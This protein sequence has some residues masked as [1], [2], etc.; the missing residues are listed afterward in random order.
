MHV[1]GIMEKTSKSSISLQ[2]VKATFI[3]V[4]IKWKASPYP[5]GTLSVF[6]DGTDSI[7]A[8]APG[9]LRLKT[10]VNKFPCFFIQLIQPIMGTHPQPLLMIFQYYRNS[11]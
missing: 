1:F 7:A 9:I 10:V 5:Y 3:S 11:I 8:K 6:I 2:P 4:L